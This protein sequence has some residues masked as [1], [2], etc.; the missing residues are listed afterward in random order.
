VQMME[1]YDLTDEERR[2]RDLARQI[3]R[4]EIAPRAQ[5]HDIEGT[6]VRDS[7]D[8]LAR[9][10]LLGVIIPKEYGGL[11]STMLAAVMAIEEV[12]AVCA[13]TG[14][15]YMFHVNSTNVIKYSGPEHVRQKFL[16]GLAKDKFASFASNEGKIISFREPLEANAEFH[17]D[18][19]VLN[20][21]K[22][23]VSGAGEADVYVAHVQRTDTRFAGPWAFIDQ[24]YFLVEK[25]SPGLSSTLSA[26][27]IG[28]RGA[29][30]GTLHFDN[31]IVAPE[32]KLGGEN[33]GGTRVR[34]VN[35]QQVALPGI[36]QAGVAR[37]A[38]TG[39]FEFVQ[40]MAQPQNW[41]LH[42]LADMSAKLDAMRALNYYGG[43][44]GDYINEWEFVVAHQLK[45]L[46]GL[47]G[48]W[49]CDKAI[50]IMG[51]NSFTEASPIQRYWRDVR[52]L[53]FLNQPMSSR[54][55]RT[56]EGLM[57]LELS[58]AEPQTM[59][60]DD[61]ANF[62]YRQVMSRVIPQF[63]EAAKSGVFGRPAI[64]N[65]SRSRGEESVLYGSFV[66]Y[67]FGKL[68]EAGMPG[69]PGGPPAGAPTGAPT[70]ARGP[71]Q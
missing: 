31:C 60:W 71:G 62:A 49:I 1:W 61:D 52:A 65:F 41:I 59:P 37:A 67:V 10:G 23:F 70:G 56:T 39:A 17:G 18:H 15:L 30:N 3:A 57:E 54:R 63:P 69:A 2:I 33:L 19:W 47:D 35:S 45:V 38:F 66:D 32:N 22:P 28:L 53:S 50:E 64:E 51:G 7:M 24:E 43:R 68:A 11:G 36:C 6:F 20:G 16:P 40:R 25:G 8:A 42:A 55:V 29:N 13:S 26:P 48:P 12:S 14:V 9:A 58:N 46:G 34:V 21:V 27:A 44:R 4:E 5:E